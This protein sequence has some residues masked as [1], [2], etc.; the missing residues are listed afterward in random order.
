[1]RRCFSGNPGA[2]HGVGQR[3]A[4][5]ADERGAGIVRN[6]A[7]RRFDS[8]EQRGHGRAHSMKSGEIARCARKWGS[9]PLYQRHDGTQ[10]KEPVTAAQLRRVEAGDRAVEEQRIVAAQIDFGTAGR[11]SEN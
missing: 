5:H 4:R 1:M 6:V 8:V 11:R 9:A 10:R 3:I 7:R 2:A